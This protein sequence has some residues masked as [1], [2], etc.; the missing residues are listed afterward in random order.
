M[1][2]LLPIHPLDLEPP[3]KE[4]GEFTAPIYVNDVMI[5][6]LNATGIQFI[7]THEPIPSPIPSV[8][9]QPPVIIKKTAR[10]ILTVD[11]FHVTLPKTPCSKADICFTGHRIELVVDGKVTF[12]SEN[13]PYQFTDEKRIHR[14]DS[15]AHLR[16]DSWRAQSS[17]VLE[18]RNK[19][20]SVADFPQPPLPN[21]EL[22]E[23]DACKRTQGA[24]KLRAC[25]HTIER[26]FRDAE[27]GRKY[28][29]TDIIAFERVRWH[30][31]RFSQCKAEIR[32]EIQD[33][34]AELFTII[35]G[36]RKV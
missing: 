23:E 15:D 6:F 21:D 3:Q 2:N 9:Y 18:H 30:P 25:K 24:R 27:M 14:Y 17:K 16:Y 26:V 12:G 28:K 22:C 34:A 11:K 20:E 35:D 19:I 36:L 1:A 33:M 32:K 8:D 13:K 5:G 31:D 29:Y 4:D 7:K 10:R